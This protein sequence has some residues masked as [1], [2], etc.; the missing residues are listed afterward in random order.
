M[1]LFFNVSDERDVSSFV[2]VFMQVKVT[3]KKN[4][5]NEEHLYQSYKATK[6]SK[7][8]TFFCFLFF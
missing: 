6:D 3:T 4:L 1:W 8:C 2:F 5:K 7:M